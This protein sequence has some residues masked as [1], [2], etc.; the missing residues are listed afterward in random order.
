[1]AEQSKKT[2]TPTPKAKHPGGRPTKLTR[3]LVDNAQTYIDSMRPF[4]VISQVGLAVYLHVS[5][6]SVKLWGAS[7]TPLGKEFSAILSEVEA[8][9]HHQLINHGLTGRWKA[10]IVGLMLSK[11]GY[12]QK[13]ANDLTTNG[14]DL[15]LPVPILGG[16]SQEK[17]DA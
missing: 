6:A 12:V 13:Q 3:E 2:T 4:E 1:M 15:Q 17:S 8:V 5:L 7:K 16:A 14:K 11:H 9:Q 10:P